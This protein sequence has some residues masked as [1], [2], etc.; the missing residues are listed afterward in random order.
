[1]VASPLLSTLCFIF[2]FFT[3][4]W[5]IQ[6]TRLHCRFDVCFFKLK[7]SSHKVFVNF[8]KDLKQKAGILK[9]IIAQGYCILITDLN[10]SNI[11]NQLV[12]K[13]F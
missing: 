4:A 7:L 2:R 3:F 12:L 9:Q 11:G 5:V 13:L 8:L 6:N 1:M 10:H